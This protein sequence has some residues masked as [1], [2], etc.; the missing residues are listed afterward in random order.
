MLVVVRRVRRSSK[1]V[2]VTSLILKRQRL[3][4]RFT[5]MATQVQLTFITIYLS[6]IEYSV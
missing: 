6:Y 2:D 3:T 5:N 1:N 4:E